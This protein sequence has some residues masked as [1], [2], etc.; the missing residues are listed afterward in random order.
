VGQLHE[1]IPQI[2][3]STVAHSGIKINKLYQGSTLY[4][5]PYKANRTFDHV[6]NGDGYFLY[7]P[8]DLKAFI[9]CRPSL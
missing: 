9:Q 2:K 3:A 5:F 8:K 4:V 7:H 6:G 1:Y